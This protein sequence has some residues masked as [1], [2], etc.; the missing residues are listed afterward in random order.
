MV[1]TLTHLGRT[2]MPWN[3]CKSMDERLGFVA[4]VL[5]GE[6]M[7]SLCREFGMVIYRSNPTPPKKRNYQLMP[8]INGVDEQPLRRTNA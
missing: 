1:Y 4:R 7:S 3:E 6:K 8:A 5:E 2:Q